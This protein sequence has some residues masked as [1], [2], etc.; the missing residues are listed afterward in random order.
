MHRAA[1]IL[2]SFDHFILTCGNNIFNGS[3]PDRVG[4]IVLH[5]TLLSKTA[6][7]RKYKIRTRDIDAFRLGCRP[8]FW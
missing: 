7:A 4:L 3:G 8:P 5:A 2:C 6:S 1:F